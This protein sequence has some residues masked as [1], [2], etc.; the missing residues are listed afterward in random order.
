MKSQNKEPEEDANGSSSDPEISFLVFDESPTNLQNPQD[1]MLAQKFWKQ[2]ELEPQMESKLVAMDRVN[3]SSRHTSHR[4]DCGYNNRK[5]SANSVRSTPMVSQKMRSSSN[6]RPDSVFDHQTGGASALDQSSNLILQQ[7][8]RDLKERKERQQAQKQNQK[9]GSSQARLRKYQKPTKPTSNNNNTS[10]KT[11][12]ISEMVRQ[13]KSNSN[14]F[15]NKPKKSVEI[16]NIS[17]DSNSKLEDSKNYKNGNLRVTNSNSINF[18]QESYAHEFDDEADIQ[19]MERELA[20][21][22]AF[23]VK[24]GLCS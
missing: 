3:Q 12:N 9:P 11:V 8:R 5:N 24:Q 4:K 18:N 17:A 16:Q 10:E 22:D 13:L 23:E 19:E 15:Q 1:T 6:L 7:Q 14:K 21:L 20:Q 2:F